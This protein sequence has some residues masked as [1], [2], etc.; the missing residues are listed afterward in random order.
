MNLD[1]KIITD[2]VPTVTH[3]VKLLSLQQ[4]VSLLRHEFNPHPGVGG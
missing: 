1:F 4:L 3:W 2:R